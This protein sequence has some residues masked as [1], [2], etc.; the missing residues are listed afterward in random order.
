MTSELK[1]ID[2]DLLCACTGGGDRAGL[3]KDLKTFHSVGSAPWG[4]PAGTG[5]RLVEQIY[6]S[7]GF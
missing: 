6:A 2:L 4:L 3:V 1:T 7:R 5:D